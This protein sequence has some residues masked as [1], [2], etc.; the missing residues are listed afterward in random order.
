MCRKED[1]QILFTGAETGDADLDS[2]ILQLSR[3]NS[4]ESTKYRLK[5][6]HGTVKASI[7]P[8]GVTAIVVIVLI[9]AP[10]SKSIFWPSADGRAI[11]VACE[12]WFESVRLNVLHKANNLY[13]IHLKMFLRFSSLC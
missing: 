4:N 12:K 5:T 2:L 11:A 3:L 1:L 9:T 13:V 10:V 7:V 6:F 8:E